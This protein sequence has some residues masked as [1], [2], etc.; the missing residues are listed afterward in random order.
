V[1]SEVIVCSN[2][3]ERVSFTFEEL[4]PHEAKSSNVNFES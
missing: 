4:R 2:C 1:N 3:F